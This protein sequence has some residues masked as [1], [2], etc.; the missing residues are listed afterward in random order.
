M[1]KNHGIL[2]CLLIIALDV[3]AG[4]LGIEA[5]MAQNKVNQL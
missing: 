5:D 4:I 3:V 2:V 1:A